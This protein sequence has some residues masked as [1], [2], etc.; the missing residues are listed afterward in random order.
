MIS[1]NKP[2]HGK[3]LSEAE[4]LINR[5]SRDSKTWCGGVR[6]Q[7][8]RRAGA[9]KSRTGNSHGG[10]KVKRPVWTKNYKRH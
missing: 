1:S 8:A 3:P 2:T 10:A 4:L 6:F 7:K 9:Y 5:A